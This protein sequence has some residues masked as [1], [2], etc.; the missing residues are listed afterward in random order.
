[1]VEDEL[2]DV[3]DEVLKPLGCKFEIGEDYSQPQ[4]DVRRYASRPIKLHWLPILGRGLSVTAVIR[5][6]TDTPFTKKGLDEFVRR[7]AKAVNGRF[8]PRL[9]LTIGL[10][11]VMITSDPIQPADDETLA[12][13]TRLLA[14]IRVAPVGLLR[15]NLV[16]EIMAMALTTTPDDSFPEGLRL[17]EN[18]E[19]RFR[20]F[21]PLLSFNE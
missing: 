21:M 14:G 4:L 15:L 19:R 20:R 7:S 18:L 1:M 3:L 12:A 5:Q 9:G 8:P 13:S 2:N 10:T 17:A 16:Q 11:I 6:P